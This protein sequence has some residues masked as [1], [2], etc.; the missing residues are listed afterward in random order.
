MYFINF[1]HVNRSEKLNIPIPIPINLIHENSKF[2]MVKDKLYMF[3]YCPLAQLMELSTLDCL[4]GL[5]EAKF[6][7]PRLLIEFWAHKNKLPPG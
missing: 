5:M 4:V 3:K 2:K 7:N 6:C 1:V